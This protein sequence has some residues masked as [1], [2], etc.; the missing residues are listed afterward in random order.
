MRKVAH[1]VLQPYQDEGGGEF[2]LSLLR[3][4]LR[5]NETHVN[6]RRAYNLSLDLGHYG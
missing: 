6:K 5:V 4:K 1:N 3:S 2:G